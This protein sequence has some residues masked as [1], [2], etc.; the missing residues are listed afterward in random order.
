MIDPSLNELVTKVLGY[1][2]SMLEMPFSGIP[3]FFR[4]NLCDDWREI[5]I[6]LVGVPSDAGLSHRPGARYGPQAM[7]AQS[8]LIRYINP[9]TK[10]IPYELA[11]VGDVGDVPIENQV[12]LDPLIEEIF[13]YYQ[14]LHAAGV[15]PIT[16]GGDHSIT[17]PILKALGDGEPLALIHFDSHHD[18]VAPMR[19]TKFHHGAPFRN[20]VLDGA[21]DP[22]RTVQVGIRDPYQEASR[23]FAVESGMT[24]I[25]MGEIQERGIKAAVEKTR[26]VIG[27][28]PTYISF[29][30]DALDPAYAPGTGTPVVG[31]L[32]SRE[33]MQFL[34][35]LRGLNLIG[36]DVVEVSPPFDAAG[37]TALAGAQIMFEILCLA[38]EG[39]AL[40]S[41]R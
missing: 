27:D 25:D 24:I 39:F 33:A 26:E 18:T 14:R 32:T 16:A 34:Q 29:D 19:G 35:G 7:R 38:A 23:P 28:R 9:F 30:I 31:G 5:D 17:Y 2:K 10:V 21:I 11:R 12:N 37:M 36:G 40:R 1:G 20:A 22:K 41:E 6:A 4:T 13:T 3:S 8:G 15:V